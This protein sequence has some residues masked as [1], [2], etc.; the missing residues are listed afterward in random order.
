M[1]KII[2]GG[3]DDSYGIEVAKLAGLP[4][5]V[6]ERAKEILKSLE[7][8]NGAPRVAAAVREAP[9]QVSLLDM[10][11]NEIAERLRTIDVNALTPIEAMNT[12]YQLKQ[13]L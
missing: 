3:A 8:E 5:R 10:G 6:I 4:G 2:R 1:R 13:M 12:L 11:G 9:D 7:E